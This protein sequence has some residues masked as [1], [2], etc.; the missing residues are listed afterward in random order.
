MYVCIAVDWGHEFQQ[1]GDLHV[2][3]VTLTLIHHG[4]TARSREKG[5]T[6]HTPPDR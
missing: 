5:Q 3:L 6:A 2:A 1:V 4:G